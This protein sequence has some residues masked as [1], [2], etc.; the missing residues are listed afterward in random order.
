[1]ETQL[2]PGVVERETAKLQEEIERCTADLAVCDDAL[3]SLE[4]RYQR[5]ARKA[6]GPTATDA[7]RR[8]DDLAHAALVRMQGRGLAFSERLQILRSPDELERR[9]NRWLVKNERIEKLTATVKKNAPVKVSAKDQGV[10]EVYLTEKGTF[11]I[12]MD[13]RCKS[14]CVNAIL[15]LPSPDALFQLSPQLAQKIVDARGWGF[16]VERRRAIE[17]EKAKKAAKKAAEKATAVKEKVAAKKA[18]ATG[19]A[20]PDP[21]PVAKARV[22]RRSGLRSVS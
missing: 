8:E 14:D 2:D 10:P 15:G 21:K 19:G 12:G 5:A 16:Y 3:L 1:M 18:P 20:K 4:D 13:A 7:D 9:I 6:D 22:G 11:K 17:D